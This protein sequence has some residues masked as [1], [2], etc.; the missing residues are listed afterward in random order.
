VRKW[1][2]IVICAKKI[3]TE[4]LIRSSDIIGVAGSD[5]TTLDSGPGGPTLDCLN[6]EG[7][8]PH[9]VIRNFSWSS[10]A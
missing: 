7:T 1:W 2:I 3:R 6:A 4:D 5:N 10:C 9:A 8:N